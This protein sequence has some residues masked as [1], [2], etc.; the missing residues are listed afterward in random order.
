MYIHDMFTYVNSTCI[1]M[2]R[3]R[4]KFDVYNI[5]LHGCIH[6]HIQAIF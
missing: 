5:T 6:M 1:Y 4:Y 3:Y 2:N